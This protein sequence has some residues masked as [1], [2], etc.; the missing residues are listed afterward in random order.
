MFTVA[1]IGP[2]GAGKTTVSRRLREDP[3]VPIKYIYMGVNP[4]SSN[5]ILPTTWLARAVK[6]M[7]GTPID[8]G[9]R[10][11]NRTTKKSSGPLKQTVKGLRAG[12]RLVNR[13]AEEWF[14][15]GLAWYYTH[16]GT[17]V[18]FDRHFFIDYYAHDIAVPDEHLSL[19]R[20]IHGFVLDRLYPRPDLVICLDAPADVLFARKGEGTVDLI[21][22]RRREYLH[23]QH[24]L[25]R[26]VIVDV[27]QPIDDVVEQV[28]THILNYY[29]TRDDRHAQS[30]VDNDEYKP[31]HA[32]SPRH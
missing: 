12:L 3:P 17:V 6:R 10:D 29:R 11:P 23:M 22:R 1:V 13:L 5:V 8:T 31:E 2:D 24:V 18:L 15:Q 32:H 16:R 9:P 25:E 19:T 28:R 7:L 26:V 30:G 20:R 4:N 21:E 27:T 14:R